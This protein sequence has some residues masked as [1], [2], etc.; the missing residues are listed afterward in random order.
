MASFSL[1]QPP[2]DNTVVVP[3]L[4]ASPPE[5]HMP[6]PPPRALNSTTEPID[7]PTQNSSN[8]DEVDMMNHCESPPSSYQLKRPG[9]AALAAAASPSMEEEQAGSYPSLLGKSLDSSKISF[10][11]DA[12]QTETTRAMP[13]V[14]PRNTRRPRSESVDVATVSR[15]MQQEGADYDPTLESELTREVDPTSS[16]VEEQLA[17][18]ATRRRS[19][20]MGAVV[21]TGSGDLAFNG[22]ACDTIVEEKISTDEAVFLMEE[23]TDI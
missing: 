4:G 5:A 10:L 14:E 18:P 11:I 13:L 3:K 8:D 17:S 7:I 2:P 9:L 20:S 22:S 6:P 21:T 15:T 1:K 12:S 19:A 16:R 23:E